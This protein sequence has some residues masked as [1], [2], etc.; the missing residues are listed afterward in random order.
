MSRREES[1]NHTVF[2]FVRHDDHESKQAETIMRSIAK[3]SLRPDIL[4][5]DASRRLEL[6]ETLN[7]S[8]TTFLRDLLRLELQKGEYASAKGFIV[9]FIDGLNE[10]EQGERHDLL[11]ALRWLR[12]DIKRLKVFLSGQESMKRESLKSFKDLIHLTMDQALARPDIPLFVRETLSQR[13]ERRSLRL[14][15]RGLITE[16]TEGLTIHADGM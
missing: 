3:Q 16:I 11:E 1:G 12:K 15:D 14:K 2:F 9:I 4:S 5:D 13:V 8:A 10:L 7:S 6:L